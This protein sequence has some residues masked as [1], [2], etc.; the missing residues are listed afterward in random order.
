MK[1][2]KYDITKLK[3]I[4][5]YAKIRNLTPPRIY[6]L[7]KEKKI[8]PVIIDGIKFIDIS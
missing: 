1:K 7:I 6:Q 2:L 3:S 4:A 8:T 5:N